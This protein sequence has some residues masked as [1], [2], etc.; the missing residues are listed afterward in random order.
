MKN[1]KVFTTILVVFITLS[2]VLSGCS[3]KKSANVQYK[4]KEFRIGF[5]MPTYDDNFLNK[6]MDGAKEEAKKLDDTDVV[7]VDAKNDSTKQTAQVVNLIAQKCDVIIV[8]PVDSEKSDTYIKI[9]KDS[10]VPIISVNR[11]FK[12]QDEATAYVG[13]E[14]ITAGTIQMEYIAKILNGTG[15]IVIIRGEDTVEAAI[16]RTEGVKEV[17]KNYPNIKIVAEETGKW[18]RT[19]GMQITENWIKNGL[20]FDAVLANND[21]MA[22]G[23]VMALKNANKLDKVLV[24]GV[25]ATPDA[26]QVMKEGNLKATVFQNAVGQGSEAIKV[27]YKIAKGEKVGKNNFIPYELVKPEDAD[28]YLKK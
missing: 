2:F 10:K 8:C 14:S 27:A 4:S 3:Q 6:M 25:D 28:K 24:A 17:L 23:S 7:F 18:Q 12:N 22:I 19:L 13:S 20:Q 5:A 15:N 1:K 11:S 26:L 9:A 16:K 21:E